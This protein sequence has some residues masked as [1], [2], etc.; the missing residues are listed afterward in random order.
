MGRAARSLGRMTISVVLRLVERALYAGRL[1]GEA[2]IVETG[3]RLVV[4]DADDL[5]CFLRGVEAD[6]GRTGGPDRRA[7]FDGRGVGDAR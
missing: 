3:E 4:R 7:D 1:A 2:E 5:M 6:R